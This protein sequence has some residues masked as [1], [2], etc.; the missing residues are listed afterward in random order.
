MRT[1][2]NLK[3]KS[4][5]ADVSICAGDFTVMENNINKIMKNINSFDSPVLMIHGN[6]E[7][8]D[9][10]GELCEKYRNITFLH[11]AVHHVDDY[12]F[13]G[14]GGDGFSTNDPTFEEV[15]EKFFK[16]QSIGKRRIVLVTHGP[17]HGTNID[18]INGEF[19]GNKSYRKFI[20]SVKPHLVI[21]GHL[22]ENAG[23]SQRIDRTLF[24]NPGPKGV[25]VDI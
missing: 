12:I 3:L 18:K 8:G 25:I 11:K 7:N 10:L 21:S 20:D 14:Y 15:A 22:H 19:R 4:S 13:M 5:E 16:P 2:A 24:I 6:H 9:F 17:P 1:L 23:K